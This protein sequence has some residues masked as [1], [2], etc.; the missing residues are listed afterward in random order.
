[1]W[2]KHL[3][4]WRGQQIAVERSL[5]EFRAGRPVVLTSAREWRSL[6]PVD[7]L[8][9]DAIC[10]FQAAVCAGRRP[11]LLI[12]ARRARALGLDGAGPRVWR[13]AICTIARKRS[14]PSP[15]IGA[16][17]AAS[18]SSRWAGQ[19]RPRSSLP[20]SPSRLP[21]FSSAR[22]RDA[23]LQIGGLRR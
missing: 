15:L 19:R 20:S 14:F 3:P 10:R 18:T 6:L 11:Y 22:K 9:D 2:V 5:A 8:T 12:T 17:N 16:L 23:G 13:S 4:V 7:G 1:M 21:A